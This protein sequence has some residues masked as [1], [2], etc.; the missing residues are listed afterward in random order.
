MRKQ[1]IKTTVIIAIH[2]IKKS[3]K[4]GHCPFLTQN[5]WL[6]SDVFSPHLT[7]GSQERQ[8]QG[9]EGPTAFHLRKKNVGPGETTPW[10]RAGLL[11]QR[12]GVCSP[13]STAPQQSVTLP[14][15]KFKVTNTC[16]HK[17]IH[18]GKTRNKSA[19]NEPTLPAMAVDGTF[20]RVRVLSPR[21]VT[22]QLPRLGSSLTRWV[23]PR[24]RR[25]VL[26]LGWECPGHPWLSCSLLCLSFLTSVSEVRRGILGKGEKGEFWFF[27]WFSFKK[28]YEYASPPLQSFPGEEARGEGWGGEITF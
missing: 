26:P 12:T 4:Y 16:P 17:Y 13:G 11:F 14:P 10:L 23:I 5:V 9:L 22:L 19:K 7:S 21:H 18:N 8:N 25:C 20:W 27:F 6:Y 3:D 28:G 24:G 1:L 15:G 2:C